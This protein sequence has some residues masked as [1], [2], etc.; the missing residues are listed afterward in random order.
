[1]LRWAKKKPCLANS[2]LSEMIHFLVRNIF[3]SHI[4]KKRQLQ[5]SCCAS[6]SKSPIRAFAWH[7]HVVKFAY[8][9]ADDSIRVHTG[10]SELVPTLKHKLQKNISNLQWQWERFSLL[11]WRQ[12]N[13]LIFIRIDKIVLHISIIFRHCN[14]TFLDILDAFVVVFYKK[15]SR[16]NFTRIVKQ[17]TK[18]KSTLNW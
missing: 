17:L 8:A 12:W 15:S 7:P 5:V 16:K 10:T 6:R 18:M 3:C 14:L 2:P 11:P 4:S 13:P 1:M 9:L